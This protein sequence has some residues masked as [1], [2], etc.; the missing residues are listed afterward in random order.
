M[1]FK[2]LFITGA[3]ALSCGSLQALD[4]AAAPH[5]QMLHPQQ[6][7]TE[8]AGI[9]VW[10]LQNELLGR[11]K[12]ITA[13][14]ANGRL[15]EVVIAS[16][17]FFGLG[18]KLT[19]APPT[20]FTLDTSKQVMRLNVTKARFDAAPRFMT[21]NVAAYSNAARVAAVSRYYGQ[22]P[23]FHSDGQ[24]SG[25]NARIPHLG[26]VERTDLIMGMSIKGTNGKYLGRVGTLMMDLPKGQINQVVDDTNAMAGN[27]KYIIQARALRFNA[28]NSGLVLNESFAALK[29]EPHLKWIGDSGEYFQAETAAK[30]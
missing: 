13:D 2:S 8:L 29:G 27:G 21:S 16:G 14:L 4:V 19:S 9:Q 6:S 11:I 25:K 20:A 12:F 15:V 5:G 10:N 30:R 22:Q 3:L 17:G 23:W 1:K 18:G 24:A 7:F 28:A 26:H